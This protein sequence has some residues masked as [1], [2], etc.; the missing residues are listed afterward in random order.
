[1]TSP[2]LVVGSVAFDSIQTRAGKRDEILGGA[3][4]FISL[5]ASHFAPINLVGVVGENDFPGEHVELLTSRGVDVTGLARAPGRTFRWS[6][7]T[8]GLTLTVDGPT[9]FIPLLVSHPDIGDRPVAVRIF[10]VKDLFREKRLLGELTLRESTWQ[11]H[12][13]DLSA[14]VGRPAMILIKVSRTWSPLKA[15][16]IPDARRLG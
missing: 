10:L 8:A 6:G 1:M 5:A 9:M 15:L 16:G 4:T 11:T 3:A 14:D 2:L 13:F 12:P 7:K